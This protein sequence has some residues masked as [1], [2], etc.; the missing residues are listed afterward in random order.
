LK[1]SE[2]HR[3]EERKQM[4]QGWPSGERER[5]KCPR[6]QSNT[7]GKGDSVS[8]LRSRGAKGTQR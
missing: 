8:D 3:D 1:A 4:R 7:E 6:K 5:S 2:I